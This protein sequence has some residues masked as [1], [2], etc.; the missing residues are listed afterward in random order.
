MNKFLTVA[1]LILLGAAGTF[2]GVS[3]TSDPSGRSLGLNV[4]MLP[5]WHTWDYRISGLFV[6]IFL[7]LGPLICVAAVMVDASEAAIYVSCVGLVT[8]GWVV[9]Q[10]VVLDIDAPLAQVPL[11]VLGAALI[12]L[13]IGQFRA[14]ARDRSRQ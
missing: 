6:L 2:N 5:S 11:T 12:V 1:L 13:A 7:G 4:G 8:I 10:F 14:R 9:W 3:L